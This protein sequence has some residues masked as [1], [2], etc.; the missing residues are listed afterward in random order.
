MVMAE[1]K[2]EVHIFNQTTLPTPLSESLCQS[3]LGTIASKENCTFG[4]IEVV[5]VDEEEIVRINGEHLDHHYVTDII[6]FPYA[7]S[8]TEVEE[9]EG[10]LFCCAPRII[11][12]AHEFDEPVDREF[13]RIFIHGI[14]H[15]AGYKDK[16]EEQKKEMTTKENFYLDQMS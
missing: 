12:Q 15:L 16:S 1:S 5:F 3:I 10:T 7:E 2:A 14:L 9:I 11:E 8:E 6:T 13:R 4:Y